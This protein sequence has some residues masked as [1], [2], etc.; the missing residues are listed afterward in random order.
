MSVLFGLF[1]GNI[2]SPAFEVQLKPGERCICDADGGAQAVKGD[3]VVHGVESSC[4][5]Q[6]D[7]ERSRAHVCRHEK[8]FGDMKCM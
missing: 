2:L 1:K 7:E 4:E 3:V 6:E 8:V 5:V